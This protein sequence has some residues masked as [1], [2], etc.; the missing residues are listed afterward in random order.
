MG[1]C[2]WIT[3]RGGLWLA[4]L[5]LL[6]CGSV[7]T[8]QVRML[9]L[10][11]M[12]RR[13]YALTIRIAHDDTKN[14]PTDITIAG[15]GVAAII[16]TP[17]IF[18][19]GRARVGASIDAPPLFV[20]NSGDIPVRI[21]SLTVSG[22]NATE[23]S[24]LSPTPPV[25]LAPGDSLPIR[26]RFHPLGIGTRVAT[27]QVG[28]DSLAPIS[29]QLNGEGIQGALA[30]RSAA[31]DFG[32]VALASNGERDIAVVNSGTDTAT[33]TSADVTGSG[34]SLVTQSLVGRK[35]LPGD[36]AIVRVRFA[37]AAMGTSSGNLR[38]GNN[39]ADPLIV[40]S[41]SGRG[42]APGL[43]LSRTRVDFGAVATGISGTD[44]FT[45]RNTGTAPLTGVGLTL[46]GPDAAAFEII[47]PISFFSVPPGGSQTVL[48]RL[49][50]QTVER[51]LA[52][53]VAVQPAG[54]SSTEVMLAAT[55]GS[56]IA[57]S[58]S[59]VDFGS[60]LPGGFYDT[61]VVIRNITSGTMTISSVTVSGSRD[62]SS[63]NY[64][65]SMNSVP[66]VIPPNDSVA[67]IV[68]FMPAAGSGL[69]NGSLAIAVNGSGSAALAIS[70]AGRASAA[71]GVADEIVTGEGM[72]AL[73]PVVPNPAAGFVE[74]GYRAGGGGLPV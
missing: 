35:I 65:S 2:S 58:V 9:N 45:V 34:F 3:W 50:P 36:S 59:A 28:A 67:L 56:G 40:A 47:S 22:A 27:L 29:I 7:L 46:T 60:R 74:I 10:R 30:F 62:G 61:T 31:V 54:G 1:R 43:T 24:I 73:L 72:L 71:G 68:R 52:A 23:F 5:L 53:G 32:D 11:E 13:M 49:K 21:T 16:S 64:F 12:E 4:P 70:L 39:G 6:L 38:I 14:N 66:V 18:S 20:R 8:A 51:A 57:I 37:P 25:T 42:I 48:V 63:G 26:F 17:G 33:I 69:Y 19:V 55:I 44:S 15:R 41:L